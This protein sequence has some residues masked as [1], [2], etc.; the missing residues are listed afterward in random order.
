MTSSRR[1]AASR[2]AR[3]VRT[4][5]R[6]L[7][8]D[9]TRWPRR[10]P[11]DQRL[12]A[13]LARLEIDTLLDVG[14]HEGEWAL[15][16]RRLGVGQRIVSYEPGSSAYEKL[17]LAAAHDQGW[18]TRHAA[19]G[20]TRG[21][22]TLQV[23]RNTMMSSLSPIV[24]VPEA[25]RDQSSVTGTETVVLVRLEDEWPCGRVM[26]KIDT[27]GSDLD[28]V[29]G[30]GEKLADVHLLQIELA[31]RPAY[32]GQPHYLDA[33][34][35]VASLGFEPLTITPVWWDDDG[36]VLEADCVLIR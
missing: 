35:H 30:C 33:L 29:S 26:L 6:R 7:G 2:I 10:S 16:M 32:D 23:R 27:Q 31:F 19:V 21:T 9:V 34:S 17:A 8:A 11:D 24:S 18:E 22:A 25:Y 28:V 36:R 1:Q 20:A 13:A 5:L 14:A 15:G 3:L 4:Q 12:I